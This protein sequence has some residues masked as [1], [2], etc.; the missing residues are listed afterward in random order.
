MTSN[1]PTVDMSEAMVKFLHEMF[2]DNSYFVQVCSLNGDHKTPVKCVQFSP[3]HMMMA[4]ACSIMCFWLP[5]LD[6][7]EDGDE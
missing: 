7:D 3:R 1:L 2:T 5:S 4:S 6:E